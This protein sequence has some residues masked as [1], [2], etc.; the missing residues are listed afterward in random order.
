[1]PSS[2]STRDSSSSSA[3]SSGRST[4][5]R[6][7]RILRPKTAWLQFRC[8]Y[9]RRRRPRRQQGDLSTDAADV[10][11]RMSAAEQQPYYDRAAREAEEHKIKYP[12]YKYQP[13]RKTPKA[14][15]KE[16]TGAECAT[17]GRASGSSLQMGRE[18]MTSAQSGT[19]PTADH[20]APWMLGQNVFQL[21]PQFTFAAP[22][23]N[24][25]A[26]YSP[27]FLNLQ[28]AIPYPLVP[29]FAPELTA[30]EPTPTDVD[31]I[32]PDFEALCNWDEDF[33][34]SGSPAQGYVHQ[35]YYQPY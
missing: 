3:S 19:V 16:L 29:S 4:P 28:P 33:D 27:Q 2:S 1:M 23:A 12:N 26:Y 10:W 30:C 14:K 5:A 6:S 35:A 31:L 15:V 21:Q 22:E 13:R 20:P 24:T 18:A 9:S 11:A 8:E 34:N 7:A 17:E 32:D 25:G